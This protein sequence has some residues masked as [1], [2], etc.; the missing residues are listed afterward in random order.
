MP[1]RERW[2]AAVALGGTGHY[3]TASTELLALLADP[4]AGAGVAAHAAV[5]HAAHR[6][7]L[8]GHAAARAHDALGLRLAARA[9]GTA[10]PDHDGTDPWAARIDATV[11]LAA[12]AIG[13]LQPALARRLLDAAVAVATGHPSPRPLIRAG[14]VR[15]E[16]AL[17]CGDAT[18]AVEP[19]EAALELAEGF[20]SL[21]HVLKSRIVLVV[22]RAAAGAVDAAGALLEFDAAAAQCAEQGL[23]PLRWPVDLAAADL[24]DANEFESRMAEK[25]VS[26]TTDGAARRRHAAA[27]TLSVIYRRSDPNGRRLMGES[28]WLPWRLRV[29]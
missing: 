25:S 27:A 17:I 26:G 9:A 12:D 8:G 20:G 15:A 16:L 13:L 6:R 2:L 23:L 7:Q 21:R 4:A 24:Q 22:A 18:A 3:A 10:E 5:T 11:G 1:P 29:T 19:A 14:W 28:E